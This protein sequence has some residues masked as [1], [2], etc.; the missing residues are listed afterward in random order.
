MQK[1]HETELVGKTFNLV[2]KSIRHDHIN[3]HKNYDPILQQPQPENKHSR[4]KLE[5]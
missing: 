3:R 5:I 1:G 4:L 2:E